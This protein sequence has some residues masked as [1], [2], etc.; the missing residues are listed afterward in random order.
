MDGFPEEAQPGCTL[1]SVQVFTELLSIAF[2]I[3]DHLH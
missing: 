3:S 2:D 1:V